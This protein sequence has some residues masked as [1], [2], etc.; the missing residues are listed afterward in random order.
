MFSQIADLY[1]IQLKPRKYFMIIS[2]KYYML[3]QSLYLRDNEWN[4][5]L[6]TNKTIGWP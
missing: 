5:R 6:N 2:I 3:V 4:F 1:L